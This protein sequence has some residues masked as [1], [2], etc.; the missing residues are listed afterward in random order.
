M[1]PDPFEFY[2]PPEPDV[3][4]AILFTKEIRPQIRRFAHM[5]EMKF[6]MHDAERGNPYGNSSKAFLI[7]RLLDEMNEFMKCIEED[8]PLSEWERE[9]GDVG[10]FLSMLVEWKRNSRKSGWGLP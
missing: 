5:M 4:Q 1:T 10:N 3:A 9:A 8:K 2:D 7:E 6:R